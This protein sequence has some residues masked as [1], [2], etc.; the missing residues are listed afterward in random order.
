MIKTKTWILLLI[1]LLAACLTTIGFIQY[2]QTDQLVVEIL[3]DGK[4]IKEIDLS[5][6][7]EPYSLTIEDALGGSNTV[8]VEPGRICISKADCPDK[9][10]VQRSWLSKEHPS[11]IVCLPHKLMIRPVEE[12]PDLDTVAQ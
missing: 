8:H 9:V 2:Q 7:D 6:I 12:N 4:C 10:C 3:Q 11:P 5:T 1:A